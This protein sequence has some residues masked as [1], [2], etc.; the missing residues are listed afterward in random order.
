ME[1]QGRILELDGLRAVAIAAVFLHHA[2]KFKLLWMGVDLFF[3][4]SGFLITGI[5]LDHKAASLGRY[6]GRFYERR[7]RRIL[8]PYLLLLLMTTIIVGTAWMKYAYL[9]VMGM[10]I[11]RA[12]SLERP[13]TLEAL[14]SLAVEEQFYLVWPFVIYFLSEA[15]IGWMAAAMI[16]LVPVMRGV[17]TPLFTKHWAIYALTPFRMDLLLVGALL[18]LGWRHR[19][20]WIHRY[21][22]L[23]LA[24]PVVSVAGLAVL[25][26]RY[27]VSTTANTVFA[28]VVVYELSLIGCTGMML[29]ALSGRWTWALTVRP[30]VYLGRISYTVYLIHVTGL[31]LAAKVVHGRLAVAAVGAA[32]TLGYAAASWRWME[33]P[34]LRLSSRRRKEQL[35]V[36]V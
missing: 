11:L 10:N 33:A 24:L 36:A 31:Y 22:H 26:L 9:Y 27:H 21:G 32:L 19:G 30:V 28:N 35:P 2:F 16:V 1:R 14:W 12:L 17:C 18:A 5:L 20:N 13:Q 7:A 34:L 8:P 25:A 23:G 3:V 6:I 4:L 29:W 15:A